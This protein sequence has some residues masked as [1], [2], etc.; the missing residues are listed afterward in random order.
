MTMNE[1]MQCHPIDDEDSILSCL[2]FSYT[3]ENTDDIGTLLKNGTQHN[4]TKYN[5]E[6]ASMLIIYD[7][8]GEYIQLQESDWI[9]QHSPTDYAVYTDSDFNEQFKLI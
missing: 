8:F 6:L 4:L 2:Q 3:T 5:A 9:I 7:M 1:L